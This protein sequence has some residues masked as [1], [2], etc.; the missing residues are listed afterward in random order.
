M[1]KISRGNIAFLLLRGG[2]VVTLRQPKPGPGSR[3]SFLGSWACGARWQKSHLVPGGN[4]TGEKD[5][6]A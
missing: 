6:L 3:N 1:R 4:W 5:L 2:N